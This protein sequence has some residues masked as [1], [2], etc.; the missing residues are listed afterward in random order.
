MRHLL[1][2]ALLTCVFVA[3]GCSGDDNDEATDTDS[4]T[5][6]SSDGDTTETSGATDDTT[7]TT[8][9]PDTTGGGGDPELPAEYHDYFSEQYSG[10]QNWLCHPDTV[11]ENYCERDLDSTLVTSDG[12]TELEPHVRAEAP[13]IDCFYI[14]PTISNDPGLNSDLEPSVE[15]EVRALVNQTARLDSVCK[16]YAPVYR[17]LTVGSLLQ[18]M[19]D[20]EVDD[21]A[22]ESADATAYG[23]VVDAWKHYIANDN[24]GRGVIL[25]GHSQGA[26]ML[27]ELIKNEID[28]EPALR[29]RMVAAHLLGTS[30]PVPEGD[31]VG[32][33]FQNIPLCHADTETGCVVT[34]A[35]YPASLPPDET[36]IFGII[37]DPEYDGMVAGCTNPAALAGG[38]GVLLPYFTTAETTEALAGLPPVET[39]WVGLRDAMTAE[40]VVRGDHTVLEVTVNGDPTDIRDQNLSG[41]LPVQSWGLHL[42]D[43]NLAMGNLVALASSQAAAYTGSRPAVAPSRNATAAGD[44]RGGHCRRSALESMYAS[45]SCS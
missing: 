18:R 13:A 45:M 24:G 27:T 22:M 14:Y 38:S 32:G 12:T 42:A 5:S 26:G 15:N 35:S 37:D 29:D 33:A 30:L 36:S 21:D 11:P 39:D 6:A 43:V 44:R 25:V 16:V 1:I 31:D 41:G 10:G 3:A 40:C 20:G 23:D 17:Q 28:D 2:A 4:T 9:T 19:G 7:D 8:D 34:Y